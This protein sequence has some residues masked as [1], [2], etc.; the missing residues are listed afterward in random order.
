M[1]A[2][3]ID[4]AGDHDVAFLEL[5]PEALVGAR[6]RHRDSVEPSVDVSV[7]RGHRRSRLELHASLRRRLPGC[8]NRPSTFEAFLAVLA[9]GSDDLSGALDTG[10]AV[11]PGFDDGGEAGV[12]DNVRRRL[13]RHRE[14]GR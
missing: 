6:R 5:R 11:Y 13:S 14:A 1:P 9:V 8:V 3:N 4:E 10:L 12:G 2:L 7:E